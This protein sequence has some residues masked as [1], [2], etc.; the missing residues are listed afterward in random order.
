LFCDISVRNNENCFPHGISSPSFCHFSNIS[1]TVRLKLSS[2]S[3]LSDITIDG[4]AHAADKLIVETS[5][6][7][8]VINQLA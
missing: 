3:V 5:I 2:I 6:T 8:A 7:T 4:K 1:P